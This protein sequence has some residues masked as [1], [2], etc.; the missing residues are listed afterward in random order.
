MGANQYTYTQHENGTRGFNRATAERYARFF[1]VDLGWLLTG[2][3]RPERKGMVP[4]LGYVGAG[5]EIYPIDDH[6][7]G[8]G[9]DHVDAG[10][11]PE[12]AVALV[13]RG[14]SMYPFEDGWVIVYRRDRDGVPATCLNRLCVVKVAK[15]GPMLVKKLRRGSS[16]NVFN[17]ESWNAKLREDVALEWASPV[18][19]IRPR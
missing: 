18:L 11:I 13:V 14:E 19:D 5:A 12:D 9:L 15:D 16:P 17:L 6:A 8:D 1:R 4:I 7:K 2:Q 10:I 3:G